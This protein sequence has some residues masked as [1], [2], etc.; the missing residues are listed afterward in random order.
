MHKVSDRFAVAAD[1]ERLVGILH[2]GEQAGKASTPAR[3]PPSAAPR[4][5][6]AT[7]SPTQQNP[8][9]P[10]GRGTPLALQL[11]DFLGN[12]PNAVG[13]QV[14]TALLVFVLLQYQVL[15]SR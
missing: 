7:T 15:L 4:R 13:W 8:P 2:R 14:W 12:S 10:D 6:R 3:S 11:A 1:D 9:R 5:P